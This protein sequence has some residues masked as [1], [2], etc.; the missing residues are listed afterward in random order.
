[1]SDF[2]I[3]Q[4]SQLAKLMATENLS[5][6]HAKV[7][8]A[9][10]D[11]K[12]RVLYL[13]IWKNMNGDMYDLLC[14]HE[15]G[16]AIYTEMTDLLNAVE[17]YKD[18]RNFKHFLNVV[19]D[20]RIERKIQRKY[21]GLRA[22]FKRGYVEMMNQ[23]IFELKGEKIEDMF[24]IDRLNLYSKLQLDYIYDTFN[25]EERA[26]S[27]RA[28]ATETWSEVVQLT[29]EIYEYSKQEQFQNEM[30]IGDLPIYSEYDGDFDDVDFEEVDEASSEENDDS[31]SRQGRQY[32]S[33]DD[34]SN[35]SDNGTNGSDIDDY[36][37]DCVT[38]KNY[39]KNQDVLLDDKC[40]EY[41]YVHIPTPNLKEICVSAK[42]VHEQMEQHYSWYDKNDDLNDIGAARY[43]E[44]FKKKNDRYISL[45]VKEF[46]MRK[47]AKSYAKRKISDSG[48]LDINK[49]PTYKFNDEIFRKLMV[50][51][52]GKSHGLILL[53]DCSG[54][55]RNN[56]AG[57][58][59]QILILTSF[60]RKVNIPFRVFG[61]NDSRGV[62]AMDDPTT[63]YRVV[64]CFS[65]NPNE[66]V[67]PNA[68][69]R[70]YLNSDMNNAQY[71]KAT[72]NLLVLKKIYE[73]NY[74]VPDSEYLNG[75]PLIQAVVSCAEIMKQFKASKNLD[76]T[77][78]VVVH[79]GDADKICYLHGTDTNTI[80]VNKNVVYLC[81]TKNNYQEKII[82][83][84]NSRLLG[85]TLA[86]VLKWFSAVTNSKV[87][88]FFIV[89]PDSYYRKSALDTYY[90]FED[91]KSIYEKNRFTNNEY[92]YDYSLKALLGKFK[93]EK[94]LI[95]HNDGYGSFFFILGGQDLMV[96]NDELEIEGNYTAVKLKNAFM[97]MNEKKAV[98]RVLVSKFIS[99]I[100]A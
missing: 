16:H 3:N 40:K 87:F 24:F 62:H 100:A 57:S 35:D 91:G 27:D 33:S 6:Q 79:D 41:M 74:I 32:G 13:P 53:L 80:N 63:K 28:F 83:D 98:N 58:I 2:T 95:S 89:P 31:N 4:K 84:P 55:M 12:S 18:M 21:P 46:E 48:D 90:R 70:E 45:L 34:G 52:K 68:Y 76:I 59:E 66:L 22:P 30:M 92:N 47:A 93:T 8:T 39:Q 37:P 75:T 36:E 97:K 20:N 19:E 44:E 78:L 43:L 72:K 54:S 51:P 1:M 56:M 15:V 67:L 71:L 73:K 82:S 29:L 96:E 42:R 64:E 99:G 9:S 10:F 14:G 23:D 65:S 69:L 38:D 60:C 88:G 86:S 7:R 17:T 85:I 26:F 77:N 61:F 5:V 25:E 11:V 81:D 94:I 50:V 49:L